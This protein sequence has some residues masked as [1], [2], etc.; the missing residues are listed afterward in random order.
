MRAALYLVP[1]STKCKNPLLQEILRI[2]AATF[3]EDEKRRCSM[4]WW[5]NTLHSTL[6]SFA[7][8]K[9][10]TSLQ[11]LRKCIRNWIQHSHL[12]KKFRVST[13]RLP[14]KKVRK[15]VDAAAIVF[16]AET[17]E[18]LLDEIARTSESFERAVKKRR[19]NTK[20]MTIFATNTRSETPGKGE[21]IESLLSRAGGVSY[22]LLSMLEAD[23]PKLQHM[24]FRLQGKVQKVKMRRY[25]ESAARCCKVRGFV[26]NTVRGDVYGE[27][28]AYPCD[29]DRFQKW[30]LGLWSPKTFT[31]LKPTPI[32]MAYPELAR[33]D[34]VEITR[35]TIETSSR[36]PSPSCDTFEMIRDS[37]AASNLET[38]RHD[39]IV[40]K[41]VYK[42][43]SRIEEEEEEEKKSE[44]EKEEKK[45][46]S[47]LSLF[48]AFE[49]EIQLVTCRTED[50]EKHTPY[51]SWNVIESF[52][53]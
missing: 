44:M 17:F 22:D 20:S 18:P 15:R 5:G 9:S 49:W 37:A 12:K 13:S 27:A 1:K 11:D 36:L 16:E 30:L 38:S 3:R 10:E 40:W 33:V 45:P 34:R 39:Q 26:V 14:R 29:L 32:G 51:R 21:S 43:W 2:R 42:G 35:E 53:V 31:N 6:M 19:G 50:Y 8:V 28:E 47:W 23:V 7:E 41:E 46:E 24:S 4:H 25:V 48:G 52:D